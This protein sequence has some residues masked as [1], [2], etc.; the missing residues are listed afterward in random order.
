MLNCE[1][2]GFEYQIFN[3]MIDNARRASYLYHISINA[4]ESLNIFLFKQ[5]MLKH[6]GSKICLALNSFVC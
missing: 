3:T 2:C 1:P 5:L 6:K 4:V